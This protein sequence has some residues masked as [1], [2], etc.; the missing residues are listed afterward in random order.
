VP[1]VCLALGERTWW[2]GRSSTAPPTPAI[3]R[4]GPARSTA[5]GRRQRTSVEPDDQDQP[6]IQAARLPTAKKPRYLQPG[7]KQADGPKA[8]KSREFISEVRRRSR[9]GC[10]QAAD[11]Y[12]GAR[13]KPVALGQ[14]SVIAD[15]ERLLAWLPV[16]RC[17]HVRCCARQD[18]FGSL[19]HSP[20]RL[21]ARL[22]NHVCSRRGAQ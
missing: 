16:I 12:A 19:E 15:S 1:A 22:P 6:R 14:P 7:L 17:A 2:P 13:R 21:F 10:P 20:C 4:P 5:G 11:R 9:R 8:S 18:Q 3:N